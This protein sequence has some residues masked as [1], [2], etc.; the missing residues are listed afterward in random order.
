M[1]SDCLCLWSYD[2][3]DD[4]GIWALPLCFPMIIGCGHGM[5]TWEMPSVSDRG[6]KSCGH[7]CLISVLCF[8]PAGRRI[9]GGTSSPPSVAVQNS[10]WA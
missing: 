2:G 3:G 10:A 9:Q 4:W 5:I 1:L 7:I 8:N 6:L